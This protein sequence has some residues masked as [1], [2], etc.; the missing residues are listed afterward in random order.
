[1][2]SLPHRPVLFSE[3]LSLF[4]GRSL[5]FFVDGTIGAG[6]HA[7][8]ILEQ[9]PELR[10]YIGFDQDEHA[11]AIARQQ[12]APWSDKVR[13]VPNNFSSLSQLLEEANI[14]GVDGMLFDLGVSSMQLDEAMRGFSFSKEGPLD[15]RMDCSATLTAE[16]I[17]NDWSEEKLG[18]ILRDY[19]EVRPWRRLARL[20]CHT[21][22]SER[23][24]TTKELAELVT[25]IIPKKHKKTH[26]AT[27]VFQAL[28]IAVNRELDVLHAI[29]PEAIQRLNSGGRLAVIS[30]HS[31]EDRLVKKAFRFAASDKWDTRGLGDGLFADKTPDVKLLT[32]RPIEATEEE[33][34]ENPRSRSAKMR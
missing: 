16:E 6:G 18:I 1:M 24:H 13:I 17:I 14:D 27:C 19:G 8:G 3:V 28:R 2:N 30:F 34:A 31:L 4:E 7:K 26:P 29:L 5:T 12:L 21:R 15:M 33:V 22:Q 23:L 25:Q 9:H 20:I 11:R 10:H 32:R